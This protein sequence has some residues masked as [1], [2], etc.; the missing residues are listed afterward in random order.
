MACT[1]SQGDADIWIKELWEKKIEGVEM[2]ENL[3]KT[4]MSGSGQV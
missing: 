3:K 1:K 2:Q 4:V